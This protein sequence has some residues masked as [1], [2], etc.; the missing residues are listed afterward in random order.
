MNYA[1][2]TTERNGA[3]LEFGNYTYSKKR[4][5]E[6][7]QIT[8]WRCRDRRCEG[9][10][11]TI[12][13][14]F[15]FLLTNSHYHEANPSKKELVPIEKAIKSR[16]VQSLE[17]PRVVVQMSTNNSTGEAIAQMPSQKTMVRRIQRRR[18]VAHIPIPMITSVLNVLDD[19]KNTF[20]GEHFYALDSGKE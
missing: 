10:G 13:G 19:L 9:T 7:T 4:K 18:V 3:K 6:N 2:L 1:L 17:Q 20:R 11:K 8:T 16:A 12:E 15:E 5:N 14:S